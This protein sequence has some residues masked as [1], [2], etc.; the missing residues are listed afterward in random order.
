MGYTHYWRKEPTIDA[1]TMRA[2]VEDFNRVVLPLDDNGI[3]LAGGDGKGTP[4][5]TNTAIVFN[6][7]SNCG[8]PQN[9]EITIPWPTQDGGGLDASRRAEAGHWFAGVQI[10]ARCCNGSCDYETFVFERNETAT[11]TDDDGRIFNF[12]KT[13]FR[14]YD[15]AVTAALLIAKRHLGNKIKV[16]TDGTDANW[17]DAKMLCQTVLGY[18]LEYEIR[19]DGLVP[20]DGEAPYQKPAPV[21]VA[22]PAYIRPA[23]LPKKPRRDWLMRQVDAGKMEARCDG[24]YTDDYLYDAATNYGISKSWKPA[25]IRRPKFEPREMAGGFM[26]DVCVDPDSRD[27]YMNLMECDFTGNCGRCYLN[28]E[29]GHITLYVHSN[30]SYT[31]RVKT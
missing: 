23:N 30:L 6:G 15:I 9:S 26:R 13:A 8:H 27:G 5:I 20:V 18:G 28:E 21:K 1:V 31:L 19:D 16:S 24:H 4:E 2:I 25:R 14:P 11:R 7:M 17:F 22:E 3:P 10:E 29:T 12:C